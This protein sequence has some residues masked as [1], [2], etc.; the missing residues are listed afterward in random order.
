MKIA[1]VIV[2]VVFYAVLLFFLWPLIVRAFS[3]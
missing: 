3:E 2:T 1:F